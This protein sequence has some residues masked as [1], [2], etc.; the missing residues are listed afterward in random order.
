MKELLTAAHTLLATVLDTVIPLRSRARRTR[1]L[2]LESIPLAPS[3]HDLLGAKIT[4][5]MDY[6]DGT[7]R[8]LIQ[9]LKYDGSKY[10][11]SLCAGALAE[12]LA[13]EIAAHKLYSQKKIYIVPIPLHSSRA[14]QRG[15]NQIGTV[16]Q[17]LSPE[18]RQYV[19]EHLIE[20]TR[21]TK[22]QTRLP[23]GERLSNV[24]GAFALRSDVDTADAR[25]YLIDDVTTTGA[26]LVNA[27]N[28]LRR[29]GASVT[30][31]ALARA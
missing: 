30:L 8:D 3:V 14:R 17:S 27:A 23:R 15:F 31:I 22:P 16:L 25:I 18:Y 7:I 1:A 9:S 19:A 28:P 12:Y 20:R 4:T 26:T 21:A 2:T 6:E 11:A 29:A 5:L 24:A 10:A 13:E